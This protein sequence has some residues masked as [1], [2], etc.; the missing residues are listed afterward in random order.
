MEYAAFEE[1]VSRTVYLDNLSP[2][3]TEAVIRS[4]V[5]QFGRVKSIQFIPNYI[6]PSNLPQSALVEMED[7]KDAK[8]V[9]SV[10]TQSPFM[11]SGKPRPVRAR[12]AEPEMFD[13]RPE[14]PGKEIKFRWVTPKDPDFEARMSLKRLVRKH[15]YESSI[16]LKKQLVQEEEL[17]KKQAE[18]LKSNHK[19]FEMIEGVI[20]DDAANEL[21]RYYKRINMRSHFPR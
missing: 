17:G 6:G 20:A 1:K 7:E 5:D 18:V 2:N 13:D 11:M 19:K 15:T 8:A 9:I 3:V 12:P 4:G 10:M 16:L 14:K 21:G